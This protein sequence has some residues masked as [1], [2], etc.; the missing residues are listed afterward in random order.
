MKN[1]NIERFDA[2]FQKAGEILRRAVIEEL[3]EKKWRCARFRARSSFSK[4]RIEMPDGT[5]VGIHSPTEVGFFDLVDEAFDAKEELSEKWIGFTI[6]VF[7]KGKCEF[8]LDYS[9]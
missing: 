3:K 2:I 1:A 4:L 9:E 6:S 7:P 5:V 8:E